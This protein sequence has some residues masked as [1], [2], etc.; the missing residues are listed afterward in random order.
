MSG[1]KLFNDVFALSK[2]FD[3]PFKRNKEMRHTRFTLLQEI[4]A[5]RGFY[6][7]QV[8]IGHYEIDDNNGTTAVEKNLNDVSDTMNEWI[9]DINKEGK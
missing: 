4:C 5:E 6:L 8:K 1:K 3:K 9:T 2:P 7:Y